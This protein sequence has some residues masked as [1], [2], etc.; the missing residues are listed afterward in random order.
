[1]KYYS[2]TDGLSN[3]IM[4]HYTQNNLFIFSLY[5]LNILF[6]IVLATRQFGVGA[7]SFY[8]WHLETIT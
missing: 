4:R 7:W 8:N 6:C 1:M 3:V 5:S 2:N